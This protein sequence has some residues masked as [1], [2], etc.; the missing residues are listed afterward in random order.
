MK[1]AIALALAVSMAYVVSAQT[2]NC[3]EPN[4]TFEDAEQCDKYYE[5]YDNVPETVLCPDGLVFDPYSR[6]RE[7]CDHYFNVD[8]GNRLKLQTP[9]GPNDLCPR[10]NGFYAHP[11][12]GVCNVFYACVDGVAEEYTCSP[13]L[14]FDEY[15]G[16]C[17]WPGETDRRDCRAD[18]DVNV[19]D[20]GFKCP[21]E[22]EAD[23]YGV[24]DPHPKYADPSDCA[25][26][27]VCLNRVT[28]R[29][30]GCELGLVFNDISG[31]CDAPENVPECKDY[32]KFLDD[33]KDAPAKARRK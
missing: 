12:A 17:N 13:G 32:Y 25:K 21:G 15:Q 24:S 1:L 14:W 6:K 26:F 30:Q 4:G 20:N 3:P 23:A 2:F 11:D 7:P 33:E 18:H 5:C 29:E 19:L 28:P 22:S 8:C 16:V 9:Q 10:L 27:Y 31:Q